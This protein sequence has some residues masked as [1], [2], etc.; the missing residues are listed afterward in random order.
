MQIKKSF[1]KNVTIHFTHNTKAKK[2]VE[3]TLI[4]LNIV[5]KSFKIWKIFIFWTARAFC[6]CFMDL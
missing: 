1:M 6:F 5:S 4:S 2:L 3:N